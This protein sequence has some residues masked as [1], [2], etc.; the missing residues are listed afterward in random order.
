MAD[1]QPFGSL[2][3]ALAY[4]NRTSQYGDLYPICVLDLVVNQISYRYH[5]PDGSELTD[6]DLQPYIDHIKPLTTL[7]EAM[8]KPPRDDTENP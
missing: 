2:A 1:Y 8:L 4:L 3:D 6:E 5:W 7:R